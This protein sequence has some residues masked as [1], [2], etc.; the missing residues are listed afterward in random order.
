MTDSEKWA[1]WTLGAIGLS[2]AAYFLF[3]ALLGS[4]PAQKTVF[5][6]Q[7]L[8]VVPASSHLSSKGRLRDER[9][10]EIANKALLAAFRALWLVF[11]GLVMTTALVKKGWD[12]T[13]T[14]PVWRLGEAVWLAALLVMAVEAVTTL[15][16]YRR[17]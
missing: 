8:L 9:E 14:L 17:G 13:V 6:L 16:L 10:K 12:S 1:W 3:A 11:I 7:A 5:W 15:V 2:F 4:G